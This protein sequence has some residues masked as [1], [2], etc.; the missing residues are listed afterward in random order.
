MAPEN[1][2]YIRRNLDLICENLLDALHSGPS[3]EAKHLVAK[4]LGRIGYVV[5]QD[6]NR[7]VFLLF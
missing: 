1:Q 6:F 2:R 7:L 4:C 5:E 3:S